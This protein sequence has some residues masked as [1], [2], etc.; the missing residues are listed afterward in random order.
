MPDPAA[1]LLLNVLD[2]K[3]TLVYREKKVGGS[4]GQVL[5]EIDGGGRRFAGE[6]R[7][8]GDGGGGVSV[9]KDAVAPFDGG[10]LPVLIGLDLALVEGKRALS[11]ESSKWLLE[12]AKAILVKECGGD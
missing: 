3:Y 5:P 7:E 10:G 1:L 12:Q 4:D 11:G 2:A 6:R 8:D 9:D